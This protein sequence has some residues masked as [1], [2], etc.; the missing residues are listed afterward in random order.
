[1][2][3]FFERPQNWRL[4]LIILPITVEDY[5]ETLQEPYT[6]WT[7]GLSCVDYDKNV[8][9]VADAVVYSEA[10]ARA[11]KGDVYIFTQK[12]VDALVKPEKDR[13][14]LIYCMIMS[15]RF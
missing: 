15:Y 3:I 13:C 14:N 5:L 6:Y 10:L 11:A 1:M 8:A 4:F 2:P 7:N 9:F 12:G